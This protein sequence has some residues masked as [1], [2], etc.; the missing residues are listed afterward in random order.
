MGPNTLKIYCTIFRFPDVI[1]NFLALYSTIVLF[2]DPA[3]ASPPITWKQTIYGNIVFFSTLTFNNSYIITLFH[4]FQFTV[5]V[6]RKQNLSRWSAASLVLKHD[7]TAAK[8]S[9]LWRSKKNFLILSYFLTLILSYYNNLYLFYTITRVSYIHLQTYFFAFFL[10]LSS[11][12]WQ[13]ST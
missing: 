10:L 4:F 12:D 8:H 3:P 9:S 11:P 5:V 2:V 1:Q 7:F 13:N 6:K